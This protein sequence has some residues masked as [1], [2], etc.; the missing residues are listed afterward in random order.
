VKAVS[1]PPE[2]PEVNEVIVG[3][4]TEVTN[5]GAML[6]AAGYSGRGFL[7]IS[8]LPGRGLRTVSE[9][10]KVGQTIAVK[11]MSI[12]RARSQFNVSLKRVGE[13]E[14]KVKLREW[15]EAERAH[16][17][18][19]EAARK[20]GAVPEQ[21][22]SDIEA[23]AE[24][25]YGTLAEA[26]RRAI[27]SDETVLTK[28]GVSKE[29]ADVICDVARAKIRRKNIVAS[30]IIEATLLSPDGVIRLKEVFL[31][32]IASAAKKQIDVTITTIGAPRY[33]VQVRAK[34]SKLAQ[35]MLEKVLQSSISAIEKAGGTASVKNP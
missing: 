29:Q 27:E 4:V 7:H 14:S 23:R 18:V 24:R 22:L 9:K 25:R 33:M 26:L 2:Y 32:E 31:R 12:D 19:S 34:T 8:E 6:T 17:I 11:V 20:I 15:K 30:G 13:D 5:Y 35:S 28:I 10:I 1:K 21:F 16:E 3:K